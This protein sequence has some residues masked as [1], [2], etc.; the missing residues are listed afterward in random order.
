MWQWIFPPWS[1]SECQASFQSIGI[2]VT[3]TTDWVRLVNQNPRRFEAV[4]I[5]FE[6][7]ISLGT[8]LDGTVVASPLIIEQG[9]NDLN[10]IFTVLSL[11]DRKQWRQFFRRQFFADFLLV[12]FEQEDIFSFWQINTSML[13]NPLSWHTSY[14]TI[15]AVIV[16]KDEVF[17]FLIIFLRN[18]VG[19]F[20]LHLSQPFLVDWCFNNCWVFSRTNHTIIET[21]RKKQVFNR[22]VEVGRRININRTITSA[23]PHWWVTRFEGCI[24]HTRST[25]CQD[26]SN[27]LVRNQ[28]IGIRNR[29]LFNPLDTVFRSSSS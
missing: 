26:R 24:N 5:F 29:W 3:D 2:D 22:T 10:T 20:F 27:L 11:I 18:E 21:F 16:I 17:K 6:E 4:T 28:G 9:F 19:T 1:C 13:A 25:S 12:Q 8:N 23:N 15:N 7:R 14:G